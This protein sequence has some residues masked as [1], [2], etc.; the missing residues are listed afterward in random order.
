MARLPEK[1]ADDIRD[2][3]KDTAGF[4]GLRLNLAL[5]YGGRDEIVRAVS[6]WREGHSGAPLTEKDLSDSLDHPELPDLDL[7][8]RTG[9]EMRIS[10]FLLWQSAYAELYFSDKLWP[11]WNGDDLVQA[12]KQYQKRDRRYGG[13]T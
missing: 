5:N 4:D 1:I 2:T 13:V 6:R 10:N 11:D 3:I 12:V 8:I 7:L 9:G